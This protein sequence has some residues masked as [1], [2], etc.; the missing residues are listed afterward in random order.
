MKTISS[1]TRNSLLREEESIRSE[2][3]RIEEEVI[4]AREKGDLSE[5]SE[6]DAAINEQSMALNRLKEI[7]SILNESIVASSNTGS[8][9]TI[10]S[11]FY[12]QE[13]DKDGNPLEDRRIFM[14]DS[15]EMILQG[16]IG[17]SSNLG[18]LILNGTSGIYQVMSKTSEII[19]YN[20]EKVINGEEEFNETYG[21][22]NEIFKI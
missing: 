18:K 3:P 16:I 5:N 22:L 1:M 11:F 14:L 10:G 9:I 7:E 12:L 6:Y 17:T 20:V 4:K 2:L 13:V 21:D 15:V 8:E 19:Y